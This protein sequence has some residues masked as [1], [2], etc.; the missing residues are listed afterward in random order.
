M[1]AST[2]NNDTLAEI[3]HWMIERLLKVSEVFGPRLDELAK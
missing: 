2:D 1:A 3:S